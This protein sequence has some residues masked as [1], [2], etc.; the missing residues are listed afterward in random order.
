MYC[1][2]CNVCTVYVISNVDAEIQNYEEAQ[3]DI[4]QHHNEVA[5]RRTVSKN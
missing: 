3:G 1:A 4:S 2:M 5:Q